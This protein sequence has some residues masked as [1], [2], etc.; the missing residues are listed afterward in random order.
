[1]PNPARDILNVQITGNKLNVVKYE[2]IDL[3]GRVI[4]SQTES[5]SSSNS[6]HNV[7]IDVSNFKSGTYFL[8]MNMKN[9][10]LTEKITIT[11]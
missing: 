7:K 1:M 2:L 9:K 11:H 5:L 8:R 6:I 4:I 10:T 3:Y